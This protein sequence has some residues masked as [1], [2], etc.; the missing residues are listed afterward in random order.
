MCRHS[1]EPLPASIGASQ[2]ETDEDI[3]DSSQQGHLSS[4]VLNCL[5]V[6]VMRGQA[7]ILTGM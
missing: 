6:A 3:H 4:L 1:F 5:L 2:K 7:Q